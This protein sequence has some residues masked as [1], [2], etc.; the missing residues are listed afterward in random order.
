MRLT[1]ASYRQWGSAYRWE[2]GLIIGTS[3]ANG[4]R[5]VKGDRV[6]FLRPHRCSIG[7]DFS[8]R[9]FPHEV[10]NRHTG[11]LIMV[12]LTASIMDTI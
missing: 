9:N 4:N 12:G 1:R 5:S 10:R 3:Y 11:T 6:L 2:F 7:S 8:L